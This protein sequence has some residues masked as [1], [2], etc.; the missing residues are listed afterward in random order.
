M[1]ARHAIP[2][3]AIAALLVGCQT[4]A[5][6]FQ[7]PDFQP[8]LKVAPSGSPVAAPLPDVTLVP[9]TSGTSAEHAAYGGIWDGW[10][11]RNRTVDVKIAVTNVTDTGATVYYASGSGSFGAYSH[12]P[13]EFR[14]AGDVL[15]GT[16]DNGIDL[17]LGM[18]PD[19]H[20]NVK[21]DAARWCTGILENTKPLPSV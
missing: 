5:G 17:I 9:A 14:F 13:V 11:C 20:M 8:G 15:R 16:F 18:R 3:L 21:Y 1:I 7:W 10:M 6:S 4:A 2:A 19:G 12:P